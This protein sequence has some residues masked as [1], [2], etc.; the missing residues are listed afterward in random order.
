M[1]AEVLMCRDA[2]K[3][4]NGFIYHDVFCYAAVLTFQYLPAIAPVNVSMVP[5][6]DSEIVFSASGVASSFITLARS[7]LSSLLCSATSAS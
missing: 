6:R 1:S 7:V 4:I 2:E 3:C 5:F